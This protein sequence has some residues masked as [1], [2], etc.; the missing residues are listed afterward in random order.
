[1]I[2]SLKIKK[3]FFEP[4]ELGYK[5]FEIRLND[6]DYREGDY[7][8]LNEIDEAGE[9]TRRSVLVFVDY[10]LDDPNYCKEGYI[11]MSIKKCRVEPDDNLIRLRR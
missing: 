9:F 11:V 5:Q 10:I 2:H 7:L 6:R 1:M 8:A 4:V 3:E